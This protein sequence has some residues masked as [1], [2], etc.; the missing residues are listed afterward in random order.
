[1]VLFVHRVPAIICCLTAVILT[2]S[3]E[4]EEAGAGEPPMIPVGLDAYRM[5]DRLPYPRIGMRAW[6][7]SRYW[8]YCY[9]LPE[10]K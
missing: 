3:L 6:S 8:P 7:E 4:A 10:L 9:K 2:G 1:M 5:W